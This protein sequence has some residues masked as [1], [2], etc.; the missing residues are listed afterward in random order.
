MPAVT[1]FPRVLDFGLNV[2]DSETDR[3]LVCSSPPTDYAS[4][5]AAALGFKSASAGSLFGSPADYSDGRKIAS[6]AITDGTITTSGTPSCWAAID[7]ANARLHAVGGMTVSAPVTAGQYF[8]LGS[9]TV[10]LPGLLISPNWWLSN[11][12][13]DMD[14]DNNRYYD[15][16]IISPAHLM[17]HGDG[18]DASTTFTDATGRH[19]LSRNGSVEIDTAQSKFGGASILFTPSNCW[20]NPDSHPDFIFGTGDWG[21]DA[22]V[23]FND[24]TG[25]QSF[26]INDSIGQFFRFGKDASHFL[27]YYN[28]LSGTLITGSTALANGVWYHVAFGRSSGSVKAF[29]NGVQEGSTA[30]DTRNYGLDAPARIGDGG[31]DSFNGW[32]QEVRIVKGTAPWTANFTPPTSPYRVAISGP[33]KHLSCARS[34]TGYAKT[35]TGTLTQFAANN[36]RITDLGLLVED[37][38]T[39]SAIKSA[40]FSSIWSLQNTTL[41]TTNNTAPDGTATASKIIS[42]S[43]SAVHD[44]WEAASVGSGSTTWSAYFKAGEYG[45]GYLGAANAADSGRYGIVID[46][47]SGAITSNGSSG[48]PG[49]VSS[50]GELL[51]NGWVRASLTLSAGAA[52]IFLGMCPSGTPSFTGME[53]NY[54]GNGASGGYV[55]GAQV[56]SGAFPT[57]YIPTTSAAATRAAD[58]VT[59]IGNANAILSALPFSLCVDCISGATASYING[60]NLWIV[61]NGNAPLIL[62]QNTKLWSYMNGFFSSQATLGN[63][64]TFT[65]GV[66]VAVAANTGTSSLVGG[67]GTVINDTVAQATSNLRFFP[68]DFSQIYGYA[69]RVTL[70]NSKIADATLQALTDPAHTTDFTTDDATIDLDFAN[71]AYNAKPLAPDFL[72]CSRAS[73]GYAKTAAGTLINF[74]SNQLRITDLGLL[75]EDARTNEVQH[76]QEINDAYWSKNNLTVTADQA[77]APDGTTTMELC[78]EGTA[79]DRH[80]FERQLG[81]NSGVTTAISFFAKNVDRRY[82]QIQQH[83]NTGHRAFVY[84]DLQTGTITDNGVSG[85]SIVLNSY[86][87]ESFANSTYRIWIVVTSAA[88]TLEF[89]G[90]YLSDRPDDST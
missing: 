36:L 67:G 39:N 71:A 51:G 2:L 60:S 84:A 90:I 54:S 77:V 31:G 40:D 11:S 9:F 82:I 18:P 57:S 44:L 43:G 83:N 88:V 58:S 4:A 62:N 86:G 69:R 41:G 65:G 85:A 33:Y 28:N 74:A 26:Y 32:M 56:E 14:L 17:L 80:G 55:W 72:S 3:L 64:L 6:N 66:K 10:D 12:T 13:I 20:L 89:L 79:N 76:S 21:F 68:N 16:T 30:T 73:I 29:L 48:T 23:R 37:A 78:D 5:T 50:S 87:I 7:S 61:G 81:L 8:S 27:T 52:Y 38:R 75:V 53:P 45:F 22:L 19:T 25:Q 34:T 24:R 46:C 42:N 15:S 63:S 70:W 35:S 47:S 1:L 49:F 59:F